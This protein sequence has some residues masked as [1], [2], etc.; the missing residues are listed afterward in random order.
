[1]GWKKVFIFW[2]R[3]S[4]I[5][6]F[7][8]GQTP[9]TSL[10]QCS[11]HMRSRLFCP[12]SPNFYSGWETL[13]GW[14]L[15]CSTQKPREI[16]N[17][18][19]KSHFTDKRR[20]G[21]AAEFGSFLLNISAFGLFSLQDSTSNFVEETLP[22]W[23]NFWPCKECILI[24]PANCRVKRHAQH[25]IKNSRERYAKS[26][27]PALLETQNQRQTIGSISVENM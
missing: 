26:I 22:K 27:H 25:C 12:A 23:T 20:W 14:Q 19:P 8:P 13:V 3:P 9:G 17:H 4:Q 2:P 16:F 5:T 7:V 15:H 1:M 11:E 18:L 24:Q 10:C 21:F 6:H